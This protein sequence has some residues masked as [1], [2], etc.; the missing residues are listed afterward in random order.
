VEDTITGRF[1]IPLPELGK[2]LRRLRE[3]KGVT[4][5]ALAKQCMMSPA[6]LRRVERGLVDEYAAVAKIA[7]ALEV[8]L[9][10]LVD[11]SLQCNRCGDCCRMFS[12]RIPV[13]DNRSG[14]SAQCW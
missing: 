11:E 4:Q 3:E 12:I 1:P 7:I 2:K 8:T 10:S 13:K 14:K 5:K 9:V 6:K